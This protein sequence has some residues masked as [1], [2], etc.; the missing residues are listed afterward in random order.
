MRDPPPP[1]AG[2]VNPCAGGLSEIQGSFDTTWGTLEAPAPEGGTFSVEAT[3]DGQ[4]LD[5][6]WIGGAG[7]DGNVGDGLPRVRLFTQLADER[8]LVLDLQMSARTFAPGRVP[9][10]GIET[11]G[12]I[13][14]AGA[15]AVLP[16]GFVGDGAI[17]LDAASMD[18][19][20]PVSGR[21]SGRLLQFGCLGAA[22]VP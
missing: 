4:P 2:P 15:G 13:S 6:V 20:A 22:A 1:A 10:H 14:A 3:I 12:F 21:F 19:G 8:I 11:V 7:T 9:F 18:P 5:T 16:G 17:E